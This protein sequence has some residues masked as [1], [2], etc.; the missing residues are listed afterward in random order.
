MIVK[1]IK[2]RKVIAGSGTLEQ[3]LDESLHELNEASVVAVT[4]KIV[5]ICEGRIVPMDSVDKQALVEQEADLMIKNVKN[6]YGGNF[7]IT[8]NTLMR[9]A[10]IDESNGDGNYILWPENPQKSAKDI[11]EYLKK[12]FGVKEVGVL[13]TDS[14]SMPLRL[15]TTG[16][17][18]GFSGFKPLNDYRGKSDLFNKPFQYTRA[19]IANGLA[20]AAV[21][22]M[23]EGSEQTPI[24]LIEDA[25][26]VRFEDKDPSAEDLE[27]LNVPAQ[28]D[29][30]APF[31]T[32]VEWQ[33]GGHRI[34]K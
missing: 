29:I 11:R 12:R 22:A 7:T 28:E 10:G 21:L 6:M 34:Q 3:L 27:F 1:V 17:T 15:G 19:S 14:I 13:I 31:L 5:S 16:I 20:A 25:S 23:G 24:A 32:G 9:S 8:K 30:Y 2:T 33:E 26:F 4:S 18:V